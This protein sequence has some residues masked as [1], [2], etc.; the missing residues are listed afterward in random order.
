MDVGK[1]SALF[2]APVSGKLE[3]GLRSTGSDNLELFVTE[4]YRLVEDAIYAEYG[5]SDLEFDNRGFCRFL[6]DVGYLK[7]VGNKIPS[8]VPTEELYRLVNDSNKERV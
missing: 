7:Q 6:V 1:F 2:K 3:D 8:L 4:C 5:G